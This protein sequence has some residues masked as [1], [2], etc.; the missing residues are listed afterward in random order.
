M[1]AIVIKIRFPTKVHKKTNT[2]QL[3]K[4][5]KETQQKTKQVK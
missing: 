1:V 2:K 5:P 3:L 4:L